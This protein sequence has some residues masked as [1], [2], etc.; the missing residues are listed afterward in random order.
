MR[1]TRSFV[2]DDNGQCWA[3]GDPQLR[4][5]LGGSDL[6][7]AEL[8]RF[9][10]RN[11]GHIEARVNQRSVDVSFRKDIVGVRAWSS[12]LYLLYD[13]PHCT[14]AVVRNWEGQSLR[15]RIASRKAFVTW[16]AD[17]MLDEQLKTQSR[18]G[19]RTPAPG[20]VHENFHKLLG[21]WRG[22]KTFDP[23]ELHKLLSEQFARR[24]LIVREDDDDKLTIASM[25]NGFKVYSPTYLNQ[26]SG[27]ELRD[28]PDVLYGIWVERQYREV[29]RAMQPSLSRVTATIRTPQCLEMKLHY[30]RA[31]V[32]FLDS[33]G[34]RYL[35]S[36]SL[37]VD[38]P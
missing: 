27:T 17:A 37:L 18:F 6:N 21:L 2:I 29:A 15:T 8:Y 9:L 34:R 36:A 14:Q 22:R 5:A 19:C 31:I 32:P 30:D 25:G 13:N 35:A 3:H 23:A 26:A 16:L 11:L 20:E 33:S 12:L 4:H 7:N 24:F 1:F 10:V 38:S 28:D